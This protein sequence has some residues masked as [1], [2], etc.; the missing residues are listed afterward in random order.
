MIRESLTMIVQ[1]SMKDSKV[2]DKLKVST[3]CSKVVG[4]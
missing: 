1:R 4:G 2:S 3:I